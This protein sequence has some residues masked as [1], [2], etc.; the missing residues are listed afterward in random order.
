[1][2]CF[3]ATWKNTAV[4][5]KHK[6]LKAL[7]KSRIGVSLPSSL[8]FKKNMMTDSNKLWN[9]CGF[10]VSCRG[11][12]WHALNRQVLFMVSVLFSPYSCVVSEQHIISHVKSTHSINHHK[13][14]EEEEEENGHSWGQ[15]IQQSRVAGAA[16]LASCE[17]AQREKCWRGSTS[18]LLQGHDEAPRGTT[19]THHSASVLRCIP[20]SDTSTCIHKIL[21][22]KNNTWK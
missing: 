12:L 18:L 8:N 13:S 17:E 3:T 10:V 21:C 5:Y 11:T 7:L 14:E 4:Q 15:S 6:L 20:A 22:D 19:L 16:A 2:A 1:M 9:Y